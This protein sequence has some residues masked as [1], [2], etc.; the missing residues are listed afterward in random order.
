MHVPWTPSDL[1]PHEPSKATANNKPRTHSIFSSSASRKHSDASSFHRRKSTFSITS[2]LDA[3]YDARTNAQEQSNFFAKLPFELRTMVYEYVMGQEV[4]H[5]TLGSKKRF[6]HFI[7]E[8]ADEDFAGTLRECRCKVLVGGKQGQRLD[9]GGVNL[10]RTCRRLYSEVI[11]GLYRPHSFSLLHSTHLLYLPARLPQ[12]RIDSIRTLHLRWPIRG[13]PYLRRDS[14]SKRI[15]YPEDTKNWERGWSVL[16]GM[17][18]LRQ[19]HVVVIDPSPGGIWES[20]WLAQ[21]EKLLGPVRQVTRPERFEL[22]LPFD[23]CW[24]GWDMGS[25]NV[26]LRTPGHGV[27]V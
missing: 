1:P 27:V 18:G 10:L 26:V 22:V 11:P 19:L 6:G 7:C 17:V 8:D 13:M 16:A 20:R 5:L 25:S 15:A 14:S 2:A 23:T 4:V 9:Q 12:P 3:E 24:T 21:E